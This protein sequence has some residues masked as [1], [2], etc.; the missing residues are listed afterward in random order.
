M[1][2]DEADFEPQNHI[3]RI[4]MKPKQLRKSWMGILLI[5]KSDNTKSW[6]SDHIW[7]S[8][9][10]QQSNYKFAVEL[11][12]T[13][14]SVVRGWSLERANNDQALNNKLRNGNK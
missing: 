7:Q 10:R 4:A 2:S 14:I 3:A 5:S 1:I 12:K 8:S 11:R 6:S 13:P 9:K